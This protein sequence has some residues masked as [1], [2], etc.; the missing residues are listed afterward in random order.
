MIQVGVSKFDSLRLFQMGNRL[1]KDPPEIFLVEVIFGERD[2][3]V[4][5]LE[6]KMLDIGRYCCSWACKVGLPPSIW[7]VIVKRQMPC[8]NKDAFVSSFMFLDVVAN[9][10]MLGTGTCW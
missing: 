10:R 7:V 5:E 1:T 9:A 8:S 6:D 4:F 2:F 3:L